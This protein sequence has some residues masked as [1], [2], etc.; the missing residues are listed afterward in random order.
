[1]SLN[2]SHTL[3]LIDLEAESRIIDL[4]FLDNVLNDAAVLPRV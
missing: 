4:P 3:A 1:L 2:Q